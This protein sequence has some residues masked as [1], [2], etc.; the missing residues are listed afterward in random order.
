MRHKPDLGRATK[1]CI[2]MKDGTPS[3]C[4]ASK[5]YSKQVIKKVAYFN[6]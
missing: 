5:K 3:A 1:R 6:I 4:F 2:P